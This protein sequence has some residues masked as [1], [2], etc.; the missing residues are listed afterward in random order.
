MTLHGSETAYRD[1]CHCGT[2]ITGR[3]R[4]AKIRRGQ[5]RGLPAKVDTAPV[6]AHVDSLL[7]EGWSLAIIGKAAK[8]E[9]QT[10]RMRAAGMQRERAAR[11]LAVDRE[12]LYLLASGD[13]LVP[14][15]GAV[16]RIRALQAM[17]WPLSAIGNT[18]QMASDIVRQHATVT[19]RKWQIIAAA[20]DRMAMTKGPSD[21][22]R[23]LA[24]R[25]GWPVPLC[26]DD[27][28][29]DNP[30]ATPER[31]RRPADDRSGEHA[32]RRQTVV[33]LVARG[34]TNEQIADRL[35]IAK[36]T[37]ERLRAEAELI[38]ETA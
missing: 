36:R 21:R 32:E 8:V 11:L 31:R 15:I 7:A 10:I 26:W 6:W 28:E 27:D 22:T 5:L 35:G 38:G 30:N 3:R 12:S 33:A 4:R 34:V 19:A 1:G 2:C 13:Q 23:A 29:I 25:N 9:P 24:H 37:V 14:A 17:G 18:Q 20:Y 16:R